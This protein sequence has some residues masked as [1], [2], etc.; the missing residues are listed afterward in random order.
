MNLNFNLDLNLLFLS[1]VM[2]NEST[3]KEIP[4]F[5][6]WDRNPLYQSR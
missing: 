6:M 5:G 2:I 4:L 1:E 3:W